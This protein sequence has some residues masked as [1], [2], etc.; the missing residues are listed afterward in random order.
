MAPIQETFKGFFE[1]LG[2]FMNGILDAV[3]HIYR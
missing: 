2:G 3:E 1:A